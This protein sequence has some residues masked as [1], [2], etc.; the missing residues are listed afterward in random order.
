VKGV[1][2]AVRHPL[3]PLGGISPC[4]I[5]SVIVLDLFAF[6]YSAI[7]RFFWLSLETQSILSGTQTVG[8]GQKNIFREYPSD[9]LGELGYL[10][11]TAVA[12]Y[13]PHKEVNPRSLLPTD[14]NAA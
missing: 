7:F 8:S 9:P 13:R 4:R 6:R 14:I 3:S 5:T 11:Q 12:Y 1:E 2:G 10:H